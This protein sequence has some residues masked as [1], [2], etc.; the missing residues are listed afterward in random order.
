MFQ[1]T[2]GESHNLDLLKGAPKNKTD[3]LH[4]FPSHGG[5]SIGNYQ[6]KSPTKQTQVPSGKLL[7]SYGQSP[8][9]MGKLTINGHVQ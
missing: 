7:H 3:S 5:F 1:L 9:F 8:F 2:Y 4:R 6:Q